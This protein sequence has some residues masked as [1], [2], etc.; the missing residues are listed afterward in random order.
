MTEEVNGPSCCQQYTSSHASACDFAVPLT[1]TLLIVIRRWIS[2]ISLRVGLPRFERAYV[3]ELALGSI[4]L[5]VDRLV[6]R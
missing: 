4:I 2:L 6:Y 5:T 1:Y 3:Y